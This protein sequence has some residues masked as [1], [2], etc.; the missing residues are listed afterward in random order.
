[1]MTYVLQKEATKTEKEALQ[2]HYV[3]NEKNVNLE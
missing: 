1:M 2:Q 3:A